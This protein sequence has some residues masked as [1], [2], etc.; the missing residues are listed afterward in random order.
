VLVGTISGVTAGGGLSQEEVDQRVLA[1]RAAVERHAFDEALRLLSA[2]DAERVLQPGDLDRLADSQAWAGRIEDA[3]ATWER[4]CSAHLAA[5][6]P[7]SAARSALLIVRESLGLGRRSVAAGWY[8]RAVRLLDGEEECATHGYLALAAWSFAMSR[9][10]YDEAVGLG[11]RVLELGMRFGD[12]DV[13][14][15]GLLRRGIA[16]VALGRTD[17]GLA[18]LDEATSAAVSG[19]L[20]KDATFMVYCATVSVCRDLADY[21][22][23]GEWAAAATLWCERRAISGF[24]GVCRIYHAEMLRL[25]GAWDQAEAEVRSG[26]LELERAGLHANA[27]A[28][29]YE[30]GEIR[31]RMGDLASAEDAFCKAHQAGCDP[32]PGLALVRL[33]QGRTEDAHA[34]VT[35][36]LRE[37][38]PD[39][40]ARA[41]L[42][43]AFVQITLAGGDIE[44]ADAAAV[45]LSEIASAFGTPALGAYAASARASAAL[46]RGEHETALTAGR[47]AFAVWNELDLPYESA[48]ARV[49]IASALRAL[50]DDDDATLE[51]QAA[52]A[53]FIRLGARL[54]ARHASDAF[55]KLADHPPARGTTVA[56]AFMFTDIVKSTDLVAAIGDDA[57]VSARAWHDRTLRQLFVAHGGEEITHTGDGFFIAFPTAPAAIDCAVEIQRTLDQQRHRQGFALAVRI[58]LHAAIAERTID[59]YAGRGVHEAARIAALAH[60][61]EILASRVLLSQAVPGTRVGEARPAHLKGL[62]EPIEVAP[63]NWQP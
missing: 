44:S 21:G 2:V 56:R 48:R 63:I 28:G 52:E 27:G 4:A 37:Q 61:G 42:L 60:G 25:R 29:Y 59:D 24:P 15:L 14:A 39:R 3:L 17:E 57:W 5:A 36:A 46:A 19:D 10:D 43:T 18:L 53:T 31:S 12:L 34:A 33:A 45:E 47:N 1:G 8:Q 23:A 7:R 49:I 16:L 40:L 20:G 51:L 22:R 9:G 6:D 32:Q 26:C 41:R 38:S 50:G 62:T 54:D 58:G 11:D 55:P 30:L 13:Q 35:Q